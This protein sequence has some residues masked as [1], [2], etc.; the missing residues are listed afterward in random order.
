M[1]MTRIRRAA[2]DTPKHHS[3]IDQR[4][5]W[6]SPRANKRERRRIALHEAI[7]AEQAQSSEGTSGTLR[8]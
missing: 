4:T 2:D 8:A 1:G 6:T 5:P 7:A 3:L